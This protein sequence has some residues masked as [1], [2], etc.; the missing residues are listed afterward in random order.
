MIFDITVFVQQNL[1]IS[2]MLPDWWVGFIFGGTTGL[3]KYSLIN[4]SFYEWVKIVQN[5]I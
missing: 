3:D 2:L 4:G 5:W 1:P